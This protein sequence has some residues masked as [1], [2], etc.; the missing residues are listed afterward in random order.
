MKNSEMKTWLLGEIDK[1]MLGVEGEYDVDATLEKYIFNVPGGPRYKVRDLI[2]FKKL[3]QKCPGFKDG[4]MKPYVIPTRLELPT[5]SGAIERMVKDGEYSNAVQAAEMN[6]MS[7]GLEYFGG[8]VTVYFPVDFINYHGRRV[9]ITA[10]GKAFDKLSGRL[11]CGKDKLETIDDER[12][13]YKFS[14]LPDN[15]HLM[16]EVLDG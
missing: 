11:L 12:F 15:R 5:I 9:F 4:K 16:M 1:A 10:C 13:F 8:K 2:K 14:N 6:G 7:I 3:I